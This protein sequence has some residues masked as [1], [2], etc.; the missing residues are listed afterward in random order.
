MLVT[1]QKVGDKHGIFI[2][3]IIMKNLNFKENDKVNLKELNGNIIIEKAT[4]G[5]S[6]LDELF[7]GYEGEL[8]CEEYDFGEDMGKEII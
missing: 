4:G 1:I 2:P 3:Q 7:E 6:S 5:Y 8:K